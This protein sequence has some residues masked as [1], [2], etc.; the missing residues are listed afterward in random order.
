VTTTR[1]R[2]L[3]S[4][5]EAVRRLVHL[6]PRVE[7]EGVSGTPPDRYLLVLKVRSL[8]QRGDAIERADEH[9]L[10][11][12][13]PLGY[14]REPPVCRMLT[15]VF[16]PNIAPHVVCVGDHWTAAESLDAIIQRVGEMLAYQSYN[17]KS[18]LNGQAARWAEQNVALLPID[19]EEFYVDLAEAEARVS[20]DGVRRCSNCGTL[21]AALETCARGHAVCADCA[22]RC[23]TCGG[24]L[25]IVCGTDSCETCA[26]PR[27][28]NC[29][30][31]GARAHRCARGHTL[32]ADCAVACERCGAPLCLACGEPPCRRCAAGLPSP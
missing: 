32:C 16:H 1:L 26:G 2:R 12:R 17:T 23:P 19:K 3:Q 21:G 28:S 6:H 29:G 20:S 4:D 25:C 31:P 18:P 10:E 24:L 14:P 7:I 30:G 5:Y 15:P 8:R 22:L 9:R 13:L 27:C 11:I